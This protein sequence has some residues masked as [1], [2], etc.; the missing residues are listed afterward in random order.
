MKLSQNF[1]V[2]PVSSATHEARKQPPERQ[3]YKK[4]DAKLNNWKRNREKIYQVRKVMKTI[5]VTKKVKTDRQKKVAYQETKC[6][7]VFIS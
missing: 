5:E 4:K 7:K 2:S 1:D 3:R 6:K